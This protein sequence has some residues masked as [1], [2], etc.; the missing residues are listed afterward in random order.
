MVVLLLQLQ[1]AVLPALCGLPKRESAGACEQTMASERAGAVVDKP[2]HQNPCAN[3]ALC[4]VPVPAIPNA[5]VVLLAVTDLDSGAAFN[6]SHI[7]SGDA[8]APLSP[9]PQ[10]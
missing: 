2:L 10:A 8:P 1:P 4:G 5:A 9:P 6:L 7:R 3:P